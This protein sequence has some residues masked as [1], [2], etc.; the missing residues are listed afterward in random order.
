[1]TSHTFLANANKVPS[2]TGVARALLESVGLE[3]LFAALLP[4]SSST[5]RARRGQI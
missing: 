5:A 3:L 1:M 4:A 2:G